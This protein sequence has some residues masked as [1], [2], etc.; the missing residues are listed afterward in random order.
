MKFQL[1]ALFFMTI[2]YVIFLQ[3]RDC[4]WTERSME[5]TRTDR[6]TEHIRRTS[7]KPDQL[8]NQL[9]LLCGTTY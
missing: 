6:Q 8:T 4:V 3:V 7:N 1:L 2:I 9:T 5:C